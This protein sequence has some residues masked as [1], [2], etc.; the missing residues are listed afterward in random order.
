ME[1]GGDGIRLALPKRCVVLRLH[2][3][4]ALWQGTVCLLC[5]GQ[6]LSRGC[7]QQYTAWAIVDMGACAQAVAVIIQ[8]GLAWDC[9]CAS[10]PKLTSLA[11]RLGALTCPAESGRSHDVAEHQGRHRPQGY[12]ARS[13]HQRLGPLEHLRGQEALQAASGSGPFTA[14]GF[15]QAHT[16]GRSKLVHAAL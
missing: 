11:S 6:R 7:A 1:C 2:W 16:T 15:C 9:S 10:M 4:G 8:Y 5:L 13:Q 12:H 3:S 14:V